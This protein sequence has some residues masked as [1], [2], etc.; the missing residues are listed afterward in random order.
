MDPHTWTTPVNAIVF[1]RHIETALS[2]LDPAHA[3][4]Y[5]A[6]AQ[7]YTHTLTA[8]DAYPEVKAIGRLY[9]S[10]TVITG[11]RVS[12]DNVK[13]LANLPSREVAALQQQT[14][15]EILSALGYGKEDLGRPS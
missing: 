15:Q 1:V 10:A 13:A 9:G 4:T 2:A 7:E 3:P 8:L 14:Q 11:D 5:A 6:N 12:E